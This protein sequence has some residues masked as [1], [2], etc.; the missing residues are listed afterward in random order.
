MDIVGLVYVIKKIRKTKKKYS[1]HRFVWE[2]IKGAIP[3]GFEI[4]HI[5]NCTMDNRI[6]NLQLLAHQQNVEKSNN[7][8]IVSFNI[9]TSEKKKDF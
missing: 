6:K 1:Q 4:D 7:K 9:E 2:A 3:E 5:K 8:P